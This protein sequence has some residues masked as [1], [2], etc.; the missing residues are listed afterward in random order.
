VPEDLSKPYRAEALEVSAQERP[1][2]IRAYNAFAAQ[3]EHIVAKSLFS[4]GLTWPGVFLAED[5]VALNVLCARPEVDSSRVACCGLSG[6]G[7]RTNY[8]AAMDDRIRC[9]VTVGFMTSWRDFALDVSHTHT[10]MI[11]IPHLPRLMEYPEIL[12]LHLP[13][14]SLVLQTRNDPLFTLTEAERCKRIL[15]DCYAKAGAADSFRMSFYDG[16]HKFDVPMQE[17]AFAWIEGWLR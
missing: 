14:P 2:E 12:S 6:G 16:P 5:Q 7:L 10:W 17:E 13:S 9:S 1:E 4:A 8:L 15:M 3:H 11:Y